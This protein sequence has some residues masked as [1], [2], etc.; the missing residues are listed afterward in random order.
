MKVYNH[1][2][3]IVKRA[4]APPVEDGE[5][6]SVLF[7]TGEKHPGTSG[8]VISFAGAV[9]YPPSGAIVLG[10]LSLI[11]GPNVTSPAAAIPTTPYYLH[12]MGSNQA[13]QVFITNVEQLSTSN[14]SDPDFIAWVHSFIVGDTLPTLRF[15]SEEGELLFV[16]SADPGLLNVYLAYNIVAFTYL[17]PE[18]TPVDQTWVIENPNYISYAT[19]TAETP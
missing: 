12:A 19:L 5:L 2:T 8:D 10:D 9:P 7:Y 13:V 4:V 3:R 14:P 1:I 16:S 6:L 11:G 15:F 17:I 18:G